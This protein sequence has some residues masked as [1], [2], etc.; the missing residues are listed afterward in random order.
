M[1]KSVGVP[2]KWLFITIATGIFVIVLQQYDVY[3]SERL[4]LEMA[5]H[6]LKHQLRKVQ[7]AAHD[8]NKLARIMTEADERIS[9]LRRQLPPTLGIEKFIGGFETQAEEMGVKIYDTRVRISAHESYK[10]AMLNVG[11][12]GEEREINGLLLKQTEAQRIT[13]VTML[14]RR[15]NRFQIAVS[16]Y[17][18][19]PNGAVDFLMEVKPCTEFKSRL[20]LWP[21]RRRI[22]A[23]YGEF[24]QQCIEQKKNADGIR[25]TID[26]QRKLSLV[27]NMG[28]LALKLNQARLIN[29]KVDASQAVL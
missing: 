10:K 1:A 8:P 12:E 9:R 25:Y 13:Q 18:V 20:W 24:E 21:L 22:I 15:G 3:I 26:L 11:L 27:K 29:S 7:M 19:P 4:V 23:I 17:C 28:I 16:I 5:G 6:R 2:L 14:D